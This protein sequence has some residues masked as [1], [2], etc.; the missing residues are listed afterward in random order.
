MSE[1]E[2]LKTRI[3]Q[4][5]TSSVQGKCVLYVMSRDQRVQDNHALLAAQ[6]HALAMNLPLA[7]VFCLY[8]KSGV[9]A[10]EQYVFMLEGLRVVEKE[11]EALNIPFMMLIGNP[12]EKIN[13]VM[14]HTQ[15]DAVYFDS[16]PLR[17]PRRL[18]QS[19]AT[20]AR[21][22]IFVVDTHNIVPIWVASPKQEVGAYTLRPKL[23]KLFATY[24]VEPESLRNHPHE[25]PGVIQTLETL[26]PMIA[27]VLAQIPENNT[28]LSW[29]SGPVAALEHLESFIATKLESLRR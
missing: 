26:K 20:E 24:L 6:K 18:Q 25:W 2:L 10:R 1:T 3:K 23:H 29:Q 19:V 4:L 9:R 15:P 12:V 27:D 7:V 5:K 16:N 13:A 28:H 14:H 11:L 22:K 8:D 21:C 17:G